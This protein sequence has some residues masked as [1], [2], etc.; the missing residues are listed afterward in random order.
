[1]TW[2]EL[3]KCVPAF[4][5]GPVDLGEQA[6]PRILIECALGMAPYSQSQVGLLAFPPRHAHTVNI[7][8]LFLAMSPL[9]RLL[10][11]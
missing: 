9:L 1:M 10:S 3:I 2:K 7:P 11:K 6:G 5:P 8:Q 4:S